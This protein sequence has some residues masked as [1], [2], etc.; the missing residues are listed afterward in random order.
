MLLIFLFTIKMS[1]TTITIKDVPR[2]TF[3]CYGLP[4]GE[5]ERADGLVYFISDRDNHKYLLDDRNVS[6]EFLGLRRLK[7]P[8]KYKQYK[9]K[10]CLLNFRALLTSKYKLFIDSKG[11]LF[12]YE[13]T[14]FCP[15]EYREIKRTLLLDTYSALKIKGIEK[16]YEVLRPPPAGYTYAGILYLHGHPWMLY[17]YSRIPHKKSRRKV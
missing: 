2:V 17:D 12:H 5:I 10:K 4:K 8:I 3:P 16:P 9:L 1:I 6:Q 7:T 14:L 15:L 11:R 13:K